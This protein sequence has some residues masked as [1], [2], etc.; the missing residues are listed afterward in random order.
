MS[1]MR[2]TSPPS[3][4]SGPPMYVYYV[5]ALKIVGT[6]ISA[7]VPSNYMIQQKLNTGMKLSPSGG[8]LIR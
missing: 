4:P 1:R 3:P 8:V 7:K 5:I 6:Y 2:V